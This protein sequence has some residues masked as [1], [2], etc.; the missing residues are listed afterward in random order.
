M[1]PFPAVLLSLSAPAIVLAH[2][3]HTHHVMGT[4]VSVDANRIEVKDT[5][6]KS[7]SCEF[8]G[9]TQYVREKTPIAA[10]QIRVGERVMVEAKEL[11]GKMV[12]IKVRL[13]KAG[14]TDPSM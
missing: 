7:V 6:G 12:A 10:S 14:A 4:V 5:T 9:D 13:G 1:R 8:N 3:G 11:S 2:P